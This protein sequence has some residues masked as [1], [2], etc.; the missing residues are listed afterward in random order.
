MTQNSIPVVFFIGLVL[1]AIIAFWREV[2]VTL[3]A[4]VLAV[5]VFGAYDVAHLLHG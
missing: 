1:A 2:L 4:V 5:M 3:G